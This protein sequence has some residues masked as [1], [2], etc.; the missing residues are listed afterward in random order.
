MPRPL[1]PKAENVFVPSASLLQAGSH[2]RVRESSQSTSHVFLAWE[3]DPGH[4]LCFSSIFFGE[5]PMV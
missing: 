2:P 1:L 5:L 3:E 4:S